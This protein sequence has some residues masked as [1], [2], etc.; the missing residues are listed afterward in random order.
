MK[1]LFVECNL[2]VFSVYSYQI[3]LLC[4]SISMF[5]LCGLMLKHSYMTTLLS[6]KLWFMIIPVFIT[7]SYNYRRHQ[8]CVYW[9]CNQKFFKMYDYKVGLSAL[10]I[11]SMISTL[12]FN[13]WIT[14]HSP[15]IFIENQSAHHI[16][17]ESIRE[18]LFVLDTV[19]NTTNIWSPKNNHRFADAVFE[20][21]GFFLRKCI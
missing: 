1:I 20:C 3:F 11:R 5:G 12:A 19:L 7:Q 18:T 6:R 4:F 14:I 13:Q 16:V 17:M 8:W 2:S 9:S 15:K 10:E 21:R